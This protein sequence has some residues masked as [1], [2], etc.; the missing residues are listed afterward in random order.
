MLYTINEEDFKR[1]PPFSQT[2]RSLTE[3]LEDLVI[4]ANRLGLRDAADY[5]NARIHK[6]FKNPRNLRS[7]IE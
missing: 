5:V 6:T 7:L 4:V 2:Q 3:Q 1:I